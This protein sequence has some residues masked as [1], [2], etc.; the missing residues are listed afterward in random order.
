MSSALCEPL[1]HALAS[2]FRVVAVDRP[3]AG[4][5]EPLG[6]AV[7]SVEDYA[8]ALLGSLDAL[9]IERFV[10]CGTRPARSS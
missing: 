6:Q 3:G 9:G 1:A 7:P 4:G 5:S 10:A 8:E 2:R